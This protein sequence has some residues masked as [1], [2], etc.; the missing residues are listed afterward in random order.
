M[1]AAANNDTVFVGYEEPNLEALEIAGN[2]KLPQTTRDDNGASS[3]G[4]GPL[5][6]QLAYQQAGGVHS[7][8]RLIAKDEIEGGRWI[9]FTGGGSA[10]RRSAGVA[11]S[12]RTGS[13]GSNGRVSGAMSNWLNGS[14]N[15]TAVN[16]MLAELRLH[17]ARRLV[18]TSMTSKC[19][20]LVRQLISA[21]PRETCQLL[22]RSQCEDR[23]GTLEL[24]RLCDLVLVN[25]DDLEEWT[26]IRDDITGAINHLR[27]HRVNRVIVT[28]GKR[29]ITAFLDRAWHHQ[30]A[31]RVKQEFEINPCGGIIL[32]T[33]LASRDQ[34]R[35]IRDALRFAAAAAAM[36][37]A[38]IA[39]HQPG[40]GELGAF[41]TMTPTRPYALDS[42]PTLIKAVERAVYSACRWLDRPPIW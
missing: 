25:A 8:L 33:Y 16:R 19:A 31:F 28:D 29:G 15:D 3:I 13:V 21:T 12:N 37:G 1:V 40:L 35:S 9:D 5:D 17:Q 39:R 30:S 27:S 34:G 42:R 26:G 32:G 10:N 4:D 20:S 38:G 11:M 24:A 36:H 18:L 6:A 7:R 41:S 14:S 2:G 23:K 22:G